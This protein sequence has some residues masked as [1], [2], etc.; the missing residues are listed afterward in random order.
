MTVEILVRPW[1]KTIM[2]MR[3]TEVGIYIMPL[4]DEYH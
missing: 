1:E 3:F 4:G 2:G